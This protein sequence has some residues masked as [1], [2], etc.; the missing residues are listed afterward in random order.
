MQKY[1]IAKIQDLKE[2]RG[3]CY[4]IDGEQIALFKVQEK[5]FAISNNCPHQHF[6]KLHESIVEENIITCPMHGWCFDLVT[7]KST[8]ASG[9]LKTYSVE[10]INENVF[11]EME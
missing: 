3:K 5:V 6:A 11:V 10:V 8:N 4:T 1:N 7:G 9:K 2:K